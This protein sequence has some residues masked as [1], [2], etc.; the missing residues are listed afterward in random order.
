VNLKKLIRNVPDFPKEGIQFKDITTL[1]KD[2]KGFKESVRKMAEPWRDKKIDKV[3]AIEA[4]GFIFGAPIAEQL[5]A[6]LVLIRKKCKLPAK[7][8]TVK[9]ELEYGEDTLEM[10][11]DSIAEGDNVLIVD[12]LLA[13]GGTVAASIELIKSAGAEIAGLSFLIE[14][15]GLNGRD[16][17]GGYPIDTLI[18]YEG[19]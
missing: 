9:Y 5:G 13:T 1:L 18:G 6:G 19:V 12:D 2:G 17:L 4:R 16:M 15:K 11:E 10:H 7:T 14:L 8:L 3:A